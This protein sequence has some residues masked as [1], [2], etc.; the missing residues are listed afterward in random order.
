[1]HPDP[2]LQDEQLQGEIDLVGALVIAASQADGP[3]S[4]ER[5]DEILGVVPA[6]ALPADPA[7]SA[8]G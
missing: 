6:P 7:A 2:S 4:T 5:I 1:M 8:T 3:L